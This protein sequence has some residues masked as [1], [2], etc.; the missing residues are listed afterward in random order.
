MVPP[1]SK[2][3]TKAFPAT[4]VKAANPKTATVDAPKLPAATA[5]ASNPKV[6]FCC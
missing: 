5:K 3:K 2:A 4:A 6:L 1:E